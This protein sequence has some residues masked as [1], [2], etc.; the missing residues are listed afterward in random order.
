MVEGIK[1]KNEDFSLDEK[2][3]YDEINN[4]LK[5]YETNIISIFKEKNYYKIIDD[6]T[7]IIELM[8]EL[9]LK[10]EDSSE[11]ESSSMINHAIKTNI[12]QRKTKNTLFEINRITDTINKENVP[13]KTVYKFLK[14][15]K[16]FFFVI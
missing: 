9:I 5:K 10:K 15:F 8:L 1:I 13:Y 3:K 16:K 14:S 11:N 2:K 6:G 7:N 12:I 4:H